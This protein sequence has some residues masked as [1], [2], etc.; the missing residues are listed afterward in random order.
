MCSTAARDCA[1]RSTLR[2]CRPPTPSSVSSSRSGASPTEAAPHSCTI[3]KSTSSPI[4][5]TRLRVKYLDSKRNF[6]V[7]VMVVPVSSDRPNVHPE[8]RAGREDGD[9]VNL[10][11]CLAP[12]PFFLSPRSSLPSS[13]FGRRGE[14][15]DSLSQLAEERI[16]LVVAS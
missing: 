9:V 1:R 3:M 11:C 16:A 6:T 8:A 5:T 15:C 14:R 2:A 10:S 4:E 7:A 13:R 12:P